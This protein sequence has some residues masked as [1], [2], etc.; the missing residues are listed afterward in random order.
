MHFHQCEVEGFALCGEAEA[1][2]LT[3]ASDESI[4]Q[5]IADEAV[6]DR[7]EWV[8]GVGC[9]SSSSDLSADFVSS[10]GCRESDPRIPAG[11]FGQPGQRFG[12]HPLH[13][14]LRQQFVELHPVVPDPAICED[15]ICIE[16]LAGQRVDTAGS[17]R[18]SDV[19][20]EPSD[21]VPPHVL[22]V[23]FHVPSG[24]SV[25]EFDSNRVGNAHV[26]EGLVPVHHSL[27]DPAAV[28]D[29]RGVFDVECD[30]VFR[31]ADLQ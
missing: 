4:E 13:R 3:G 2:D 21:E 31:R 17:D 26:L 19:V 1:I 12:A 16:N 9:Q 30:W 11:V 8:T 25:L 23:L 7:G 29:R 28:A 18:G 10:G 14:R 22:G 20:I 15:D 5:V 27:F 24:P 6:I